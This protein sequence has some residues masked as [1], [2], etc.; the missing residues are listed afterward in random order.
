MKFRWGSRFILASLAMVL[1]LAFQNC[2]GSP[3]TELASSGTTQEKQGNGEGYDGKIFVAPNLSPCPDGSPYKTEL[4]FKSG[5]AYLTR[6]NCRP[7]APRLVPRESVDI[8]PHNL[9]FLIYEGRL[10]KNKLVIEIGSTSGHD[11]SLTEILFCRGVVSASNRLEIHDLLLGTS[12]TGPAA[13]FSR[14]IYQDEA[15][16]SF[17]SR[18]TAI[19][20][21]GPGPDSYSAVV[22]SPQFA[23][24]SFNS[25]LMGQMNY[26][27]I[28]VGESQAFSGNLAIQCFEY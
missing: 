23:Y 24:F 4:E 26:N 17:R 6:E 11:P 16:Q 25:S 28:P 27:L 15:L 3:F 1:V 14:A 7:I 22:T 8:R 18:R 2:G 19:Q 5:G 12:G 10:L 20:E 9:T 13:Q 21:T